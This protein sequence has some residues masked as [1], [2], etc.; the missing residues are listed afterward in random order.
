M[1]LSQRRTQPARATGHVS[2]DAQ[3]RID[4]RVAT[5]LARRESSRPAAPTAARRP[6][7]RGAAK[8]RRE[9]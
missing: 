5:I 2:H 9:R 7:D 8:T 3:A 6:T 1:A 4:E